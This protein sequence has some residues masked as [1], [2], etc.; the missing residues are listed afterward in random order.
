MFMSSKANRGNTYPMA[1][2]LGKR[3]DMVATVEM[4]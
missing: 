2:L 4:P 3:M 1:R